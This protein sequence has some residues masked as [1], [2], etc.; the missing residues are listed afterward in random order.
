MKLWS[1]IALVIVGI[2]VII[3]GVV[4]MFKHQAYENAFQHHLLAAFGHDY[5]WR[6]VGD[7]Y[8]GIAAVTVGALMMTAAAIMA[9][10]G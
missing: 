10:F 2:S 1:Q 3:V 4:L 6:S 9:R 5:H 7:A 8:T